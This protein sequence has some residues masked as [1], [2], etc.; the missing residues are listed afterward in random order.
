VCADGVRLTGDRASHMSSA[1]LLSALGALYHH[2]DPKVKDEADRWLEAWQQSTEAW[3]VADGVLHDAGSSMEAQYFCAQ[4]LRTKVG[5]RGA[6]R[7]MQRQICRCRAFG[8]LPTG[9][10][11]ACVPHPRCSAI[12]KSCQPTRWTACGTACWRC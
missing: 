5:G 3:S 7:S 10:M 6:R 9:R 4:T 11:H 12:L 2:D 8:Q 1:Q